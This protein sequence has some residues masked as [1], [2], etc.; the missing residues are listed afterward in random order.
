[1]GY[2]ILE[3]FDQYA[4]DRLDQTGAPYD[5]ETDLWEIVSGT[6]GNVLE[7]FDSTGLTENASYVISTSG[8]DTYPEKGDH[9]RVS[10]SISQYTGGTPFAF[11]FA[12]SSITDHYRV[13]ID[14]NYGSIDIMEESGGSTSY[15]N[16][17]ET[18]ITED[19]YLLDLFWEHP[20][21]TDD[22]V[23]ELRK[24]DETLVGTVGANG[25]AH[26]TGAI[27]FSDFQQKVKW[28]SVSKEVS[29]TMYDRI[30]ETHIL[31]SVTSSTDTNEIDYFDSYA[32]GDVDNVTNGVWT[33]TGEIQTDSDAIN[34][35]QSLVGVAR[36]MSGLQ[37]Y[38]EPGTRTVY[39]TQTNLTNDYSSLLFGIEE[40][41]NGGYIEARLSPEGSSSDKRIEIYESSPDFAG[42]Q[43]RGSTEIK[44][45]RSL[46]ANWWRVEVVWEDDFTVTAKANPI[47]YPDQEYH[48]DAELEHSH[49]PEGLELG[50]D[51]LPEFDNVRL[52][53]QGDSVFR[54]NASYTGQADTESSRIFDGVRF[55]GTNTSPGQ[56]V[57]ERR[58]GRYP[59]SFGTG[60]ATD[61]TRA[62][63][64]PR[65]VSTFAGGMNT[66][67]SRD[68]NLL[69]VS[70]G[71][72]GN[73]FTDSGRVAT[74]NVYTESYVAPSG[75]NAYSQYQMFATA[76]SYANPATTASSTTS[77]LDSDVYRH[78]LGMEYHG[79]V[80][81]GNYNISFG[82][83]N[84]SYS[85]PIDTTSS[86]FVGI[87]RRVSNALP[88][89]ATSS[90]R[91]R[92]FG[93]LS[94][95]FTN[96]MDTETGRR[97][98][99]TRPVQ[100]AGG[101]I[102]TSVGRTLASVRNG[103]TYV[104][105]AVTDGTFNR[106]YTRLTSTFQSA[107]TSDSTRSLSLRRLTESVSGASSTV[108]SRVMS[109]IRP[110]TS[111]SATSSTSAT[112]LELI[113]RRA[114]SSLNTAKT[115]TERTL[116]QFRPSESYSEQSDTNTRRVIDVAVSATSYAKQ[117]ATRAIPDTDRPVVGRTFATIKEKSTS[118]LTRD[119]SSSVDIAGSSKR[120]DREIK[121]EDK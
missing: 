77:I 78:Y 65:A 30:S 85:E 75:S 15:L 35:S 73:A 18:E 60:M 27:G 62:I 40:V 58:A 12:G 102:Q 10:V 32:T 108:N 48:V 71:V 54:W 81:H 41:E 28:E 114:V 8:L 100:T 105:N 52:Y 97:V 76:R 98:S 22:I 116:S 99:L 13:G 115:S 51:E 63:T 69:R 9:I 11:I 107:T 17:T 25:Q 5:G 96:P 79:Q 83:D 49:P 50:G 64:Y 20:D 80:D 86:V 94:D 38:P 44:S 16:Y 82:R 113:R 56:T 55:A 117:V 36:S 111:Y 112:T 46:R 42:S 61:S 31:P 29:A 21:Y 101:G 59:T 45:S 70:E 39:Y 37:R 33:G 118:V 92:F 4:T 120:I 91:T 106:I 104:D 47:N 43:L 19:E 34:G 23:L 24:K 1:M 7:N 119:T 95:S 3:D 87:L 93:R 67:A 84:E 110:L 2:K 74:R 121:D 14:E 90:D 66:D 6:S 57:S 26:S 72:S 109:L 68:L 53:D 89:S 103:V 88:A